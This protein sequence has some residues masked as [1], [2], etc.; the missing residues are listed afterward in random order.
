MYGVANVGFMCST[1][2]T[3]RVCPLAVRG[4][5]VAARRGTKTRQAAAAAT[6]SPG[7]APQTQ[8]CDSTAW[9]GAARATRAGPGSA[10]SCFKGLNL[11]SNNSSPEVRRTSNALRC[12]AQ[13][14]WAP[15]VLRDS[16]AHISTLCA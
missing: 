13:S 3:S 16:P 1:N 8:P 12:I 2:W 11:L 10:S 9:A 6:R 4:P 15:Y 5:A 14:V 7:G